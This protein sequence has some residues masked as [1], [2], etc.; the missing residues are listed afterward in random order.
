M[1]LI[2]MPESDTP[3]LADRLPMLDVYLPMMQSA[4]LLAAGRL[5]LFEALAAGPLSV[6]SLAQLLNSDSQSLG[7]LVDF[8]LALKFL[9]QSDQGVCNAPH[10]RRWFTSAGSVDY[11]PGL[12]WTQAVWNMVGELGE[13]VQSGAPREILWDRMRVSP[14]LG[15]DFSAYMRAFARDLGPDL[16]RLVPLQSDHVRLLDLGGSHCLHSMRFCAHYPQLQATIVDLPSALQDTTEALE[17]AG[18]SGRIKLSPGNLLQ[19]P[20]DH[21]Q[22][23]VFYLSVAHNQTPADNQQVLRRIRACLNPGGMLVIHEYLADFLE[24]PYYAAFRLTLLLETGTTIYAYADFESWLLAVGFTEVQRI[25]LSP[26]E[27]GSLLIA[28]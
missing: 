21:G 4:A 19:H 1:S 17:K 27:K 15:T 6:E 18:L 24:N 28:R 25:D 8:L 2:S 7:R 3:P 22:D 20:W 10:T 26:V 12:R 5:G 14:Q 23:V 11:T 13:V 9:Q 16:L